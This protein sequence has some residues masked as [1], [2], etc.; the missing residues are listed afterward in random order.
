LKEQVTNQ[1]W[2]ITVA[3]VVLFSVSLAAHAATLDFP[4][5]RQVFQR[6]Q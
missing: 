3:S 2:H 4:L 1:R 5:E 6:N